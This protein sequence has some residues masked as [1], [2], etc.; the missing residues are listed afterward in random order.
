MPLQ[1][2]PLQYL[3]RRRELSGHVGCVRSIRVPRGLHSMVVLSGLHIHMVLGFYNGV[4]DA[5]RV[6]FSS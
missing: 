5:M 3:G 1:S 4:Y 6:L 2:L